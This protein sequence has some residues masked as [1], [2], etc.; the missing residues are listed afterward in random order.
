LKM[1]SYKLIF[2]NRILALA[3]LSFVISSQVVAREYDPDNG[4]EIN[5]VCAGCH[6][7]FGQGGGDGE[8]PRL[9]GMPAAFIA[10]QL[11]LFRDRKRPNMAM[12]EYID[13]RQMPDSDIQ[14]IAVFLARITLKTKLPPANENDPGFNAYA[15]L[16][17]SK[18]VMQIP[19]AEGDQENGRK[20][21][22]KECASCHGKLGEGD[23]EKAVPM[24]TGQYIDY[25]WRQVEKYR[26][27]IRIHDPE[28][29]EDQLLVE[30]SDTE[31]QDIFAYLSILD[32]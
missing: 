12:I 8:Y 29:P 11:H 15:R 21:Y 28:A 16:L 4:E 9:A 20:I 7:E 5:E 6:G 27:N 10:R 17:A 19:R 18:Q 1:A 14:D 32:D 13:E 31:L 22:R 30:F 26:E 25:L 3:L 23:Q 24:L 2:P